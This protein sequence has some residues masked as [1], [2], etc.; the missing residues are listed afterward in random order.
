MSCSVGDLAQDDAF[1]DK[2]WAEIM[3]VLLEVQPDLGSRLNADL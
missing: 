1:M 3:E 2:T